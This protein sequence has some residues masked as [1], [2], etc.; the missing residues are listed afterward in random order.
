MINSVT[1]LVGDRAAEASLRMGYLPEQ[2][3]PERSI[4]AHGWRTVSRVDGLKAG[5]GTQDSESTAYGIMVGSD[6][7]RGNL[8]LGVA[9]HIG[10]ANTD[11]LGSHSGEHSSSDFY[12]LMAYGKLD[13]GNWSITGDAGYTW[14]KT[15]YDFK[16]GSSTTGV[17]A[18][19]FSVGAKASYKIAAGGRMNI[20]PFVG[21]RYNHYTQDSYK[22]GTGT[23]DSYSYNQFL[24][25]VGV[26]FDWENIQTKS[27]WNL[28]PSVEFSYIR[29]MGDLDVN[30][31]IRPTSGGDATT[32]IS[33]L[34]DA[35]TLAAELKLEAKKANFTA[36]INLNGRISQNQKDWG[37]G[38]T[39]KWEI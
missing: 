2:P 16:I 25:P 39:F 22:Y 26:K 24:L 9:G 38:T 3:K 23:A 15:D 1:S 36:S 12:G 11:G 29:T 14:F 20:S 34:S 31:K 32:S 27:G 33:A 21:L 37:I 5:S 17:D 10:K 7:K 18:G 6:V 8:L 19:L 28:K 30:T 35:N 13:A 4:W